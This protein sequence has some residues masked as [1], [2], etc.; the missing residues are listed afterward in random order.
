MSSRAP[1]QESSG[2]DILPPPRKVELKSPWVAL[3]GGLTIGALCVMIYASRKG[4]S[5]LLQKSMRARVVLQGITVGIMAASSSYVFKDQIKS[6]TGIDM[7]M[8]NSGK[9]A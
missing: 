3:G 6:A 1:G 9:E 5:D 2:D 7:D 4:H 8:I